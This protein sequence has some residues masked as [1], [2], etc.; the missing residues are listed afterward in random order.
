MSSST[1]PVPEAAAEL[2]ARSTH[3][4]GVPEHVRDA[5]V[6]ALIAELLHNANGAGPKAGTASKTCTRPSHPSRGR[7]G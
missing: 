7:H 5:T 6:L 3:A 2:V 1:T 4:S